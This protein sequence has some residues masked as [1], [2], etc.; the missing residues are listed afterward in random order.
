MKYIKTKRKG[1]WLAKSVEHVILRALR[2]SPTLGFEV[3]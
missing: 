3:Y 1:A 2:S